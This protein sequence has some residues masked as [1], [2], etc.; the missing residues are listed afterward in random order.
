MILRSGMLDENA[1]DRSVIKRLQKVWQPQNVAVPCGMAVCTECLPHGAGEKGILPALSAELAV[2]GAVN[3]LAAKGLQAESIQINVL[4]PEGSEESLLR[5]VTDGVFA[6]AEKSDV[7]VSDFCGMVTTAAAAPV[8]TAAATSNCQICTECEC[9]QETDPESETPGGILAIGHIAMEGTAILTK[10][11]RGELEKR[12]PVQLLNRSEELL[13]DLRI[14]PAVREM[15]QLGI[16]PRRMVAASDGGIYAAL[17]EISCRCGCGMEVSLPEIPI[18]QESIEIT[19]YLGINPYQIKSKGL[20][21]AVVLHA[22]EAAERLLDHGIYARPIGIL[23]AG[24]DKVIV[25]G[26]ERQNLNRPEPDGVMR[27]LEKML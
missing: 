16:R 24:R 14:L 20:A 1:Y 3:E 15:S 17:W 18:R 7:R 5:T 21:L 13:E 6:A 26:E 22:E 25:N 2:I 4:L 23:T 11:R 8:V 12:F 19:D 9:R 10:G 27:F